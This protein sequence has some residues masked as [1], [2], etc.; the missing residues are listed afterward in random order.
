MS[1]IIV[2]QR[3]EVVHQRIINNRAVYGDRKLLQSVLLHSLQIF[4]RTDLE[5]EIVAVAIS[6]YAFCRN[7]DGTSFYH[8]TSP[9][10]P[11]LTKESQFTRALEVFDGNESTRLSGL[12]KLG[13][14]LG[15][16]TSKYDVF[17]LASSALSPNSAQ[18]VLHRLLR[19]IS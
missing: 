2:Y 15:D 6:G 16:D 1:L 17:L 14:H 18:W 4:Y 10:S 5:V 3:L 11:V 19:I 9:S 7:K 12:G 8:H 13:F